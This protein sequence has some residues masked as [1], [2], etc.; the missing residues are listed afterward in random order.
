M[1]AVLLRVPFDRAPWVATLS[2][3]FFL[4]YLSVG[5]L[6]SFGQPTIVGSFMVYLLWFFPLLAFNRF[7]NLAINARDAMPDGG[8]L[9]ACPRSKHVSA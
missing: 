1:L 8:Q 4:A 9:L 2:S 5:A 7:A 3:A 6:L